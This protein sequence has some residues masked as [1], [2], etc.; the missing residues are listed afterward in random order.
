MGDH[1]YSLPRALNDLELKSE[2]CS[3]K[4]EGGGLGKTPSKGVKRIRT[5]LGVDLA[6][7]A[8]RAGGWGRGEKSRQLYQGLSETH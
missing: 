3:L 8:A 1:R 7:A 2:K 6:L 5:L 4:K